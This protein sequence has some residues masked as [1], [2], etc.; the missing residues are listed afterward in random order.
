MA[1][2]RTLGGDR[3][4]SGK[5]M[6]VKMHGYGKST[7]NL[8]RIIKLTQ[9]PGVV[10]PILTEPL[11]AGDSAK[12]E[13]TPLIRTLPTN[14]PAFASFLWQAHAFWVPMRLY[15]AQLHNNRLDI[16]LNIEQ[17]QFPQMS[18]Q[19]PQAD[20]TLPR[21][22]EQQVNPSSLLAYLGIRGGGKATGVQKGINFTRKFQAMTMLA[23]YD[24]YK[25]FYA[26]KQ[27]GNGQV[28][29][30][31]IVQLP[32]LA[33]ITDGN[34]AAMNQYQ[35]IGK[36]D[37]D[38]GFSVQGRANGTKIADYTT[39]NQAVATIIEPTVIQMSGTNL[40][41]ENLQIHYVTGATSSGA[42]TAT[43][44]QWLQNGWIS[45]SSNEE[46]TDY[47]SIIINP[48]SERYLI[49]TGGVTIE[50]TPNAAT[51]RAVAIK[52]FPL[53]NIDQMRDKILAAPI[54]AP[55]IL[56]Q[57][58]QLPYSA[59][60]GDADTPSPNIGEMVGLLLKTYQSD[61]FQNWLDTDWIDGADG[62]SAKTAVDTSEGNFTMD[63]LNLQEKLYNLLNRIGAA[64]GSYN[65]YISAAYGFDANRN[66]EI[67]QFRGGMSAEIV[68]NEV[69]SM[70]D[71]QL[72]EGVQ[73]LGSL[74]GRGNTM[75]EKGGKI[76]F[77]ATEHGFIMVM[78]S[79]TPRLDY[80]QGNKW[81]NNWTN[82]RQ[83]HMPEL[84]GIGFQNLMTGEMTAFDETVETDGSITTKSIGKQP[85]WIEYMTSTNEVY[86]D[87]T[88]GRS[89]D[90]MV[91]NRDYGH[92]ENGNLNDTTTYI[93]PR[94]FSYMFASN[95]LPDTA[96]AWVQVGTKLRVKRIMSAHLIPSM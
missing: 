91:L 34:T 7:H 12:L 40:A 3:L 43:L 66:A 46:Q 49:N 70:A 80:C 15:N 36:I 23:Y 44:L 47:L 67:P 37:E 61:R 27:E 75:N 88:A 93:D 65:D 87:F 17:V 13:L 2:V 51:I 35:Q 79:I 22:N 72:N 18:L 20:L 68:F 94:K 89:L 8:D 78:A 74:A 1:I 83:L 63:T 32:D 85:A 29:G 95:E 56:A 41:L 92:D 16:G 50:P 10:I 9:A 14:G 30:T 4:G 33:S 54:S 71:S 28:I 26:N 38:E 86:G 73:P 96:W 77:N 58:E 39:T 64:G 45:R 6:S 60:L 82:L 62:I 24:I 57:G 25:N 81:W 11:L 31:D 5:K 59:I 42:Q 90:W 48:A 69:V 84:D 53:T 52:E 76:T 55:L 21:I 19:I